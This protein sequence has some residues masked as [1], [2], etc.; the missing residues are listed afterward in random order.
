MANGN[1]DKLKALT[2]VTVFSVTLSLNE[3]EK[4]FRLTENSVTEDSSEIKIRAK[5]NTEE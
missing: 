4:K 5:G 1:S 2:S 3:V